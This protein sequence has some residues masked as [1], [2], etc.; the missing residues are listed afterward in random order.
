MLRWWLDDALATVSV[1]LGFHATLLFHPANVSL[2]QT[3]T[4]FSSLL[5]TI[6]RMSDL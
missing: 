5:L 4:D 1:G 6:L 3:T 2:L